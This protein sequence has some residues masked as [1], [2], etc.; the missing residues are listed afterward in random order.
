MA[1]GDGRVSHLIAR[2]STVISDQWGPRDNPW[3]TYRVP[4]L[5]LLVL[6]V[7]TRGQNK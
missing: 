4:I 3:G 1:E 5:V 6:L 7:L 2:Q